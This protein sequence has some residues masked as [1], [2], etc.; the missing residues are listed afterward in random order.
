M[1]KKYLLVFMIL[2]FTANIFSQVRAPS[3]PAKP[4]VSQDEGKKLRGKREFHFEDVFDIRFIK[5][6]KITDG[7]ISVD[8][9]FSQSLNPGSVS[10][11]KLWINEQPADASTQIAFSRNGA[12]IRITID[13]PAE[14]FSL[15]IAGLESTRGL[16]IKQ[17][18][19]NGLCEDFK[20]H[21]KKE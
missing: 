3:A 2:L 7:K 14:K 15:R 8:L 1:M 4:Q 16:K 18:T 13:A 17:I 20:R 11:E 21:N 5:V 12:W 10:V 19:L 6:G 9:G